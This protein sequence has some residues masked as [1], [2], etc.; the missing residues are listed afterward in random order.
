MDTRRYRVFVDGKAV[1]QA[2][3]LEYAILFIK[4]VFEEY[5]NEHDM[6]VM[7]REMPQ[8]VDEDEIWEQNSMM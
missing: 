8:E 5:Y 7:I 6:E 3:P 2:M 4:A 1:A